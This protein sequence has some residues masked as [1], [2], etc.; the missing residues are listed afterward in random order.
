MRLP[1]A[2]MLRAHSRASARVRATTSP[3]RLGKSGPSPHP[4]AEF[5][6]AGK[7]FRGG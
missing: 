7:G 2:R 6:S 5:R 4:K 3:E 1:A